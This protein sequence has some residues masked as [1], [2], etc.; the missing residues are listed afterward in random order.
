MLKDLEAR[1]LGHVFPNILFGMKGG[2]IVGATL[3]DASYDE[4]PFI[5]FSFKFIGDL[6]S[7]MRSVNR[8]EQIAFGFQNA[9]QLLHPT[10]L[11]VV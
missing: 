7:V 9:M 4:F 11:E 10:F 5:E 6:I 1:F 3:T 8:Y 2:A